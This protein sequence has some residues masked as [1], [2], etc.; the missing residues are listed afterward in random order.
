MESHLGRGGVGQ[1]LV[2]AAL[3]LTATAA[4]SSS[5]SGGGPPPGGTGSSSG[6]TSSSGGTTGCSPSSSVPCDTGSPYTCTGGDHPANHDPSLTCGTASRQP[7]GTDAFCCVTPISGSTCAE[8]LNVLCAYPRVG[9]S[10]TGSDTPDQ[11]EP[12]LTC[13]AVAIDPTT[14]HSLYCCY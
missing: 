8:N 5:S 1:G 6:T 10:C 3:A 11:G 4:C 13:D 12:K 7:D 2:I 9:Y 14:G